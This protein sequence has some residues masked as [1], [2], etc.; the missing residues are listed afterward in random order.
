MAT[1][2]GG[3][4]GLAVFGL[5]GAARVALSTTSRPTPSGELLASIAWWVTLFTYFVLLPS[6][7]VMS[8]R[9]LLAPTWPRRELMCLVGGG[10]LAVLFLASDGHVLSVPNADVFVGLVCYV[11]A[12]TAFVLA[13]ARSVSTWRAR[14]SS[15]FIAAC[16]VAVVAVAA[17]SS[18]SWVVLFFE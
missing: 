14:A 17:L 15:R 1:C 13:L 5:L 6:L 3:L 9:L 4:A 7:V 10:V 11:C 2:I 18:G 8:R 12:S 16:A